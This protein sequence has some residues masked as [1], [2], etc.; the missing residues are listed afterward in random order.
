M[1]SVIADVHIGNHKKFG[2]PLVG[3]LNR[4]CRLA[5]EVLKKAVFAAGSGDLVIC[6]DLFDV[7]YPSPPVVSAVMGALSRQSGTTY[8]L[9]G[10]HDMHSSSGSDDAL[11]PLER[12]TGVRVV[13]EKTSMV[14]S[15]YRAV[16]LP[17][18]SSGSAADDL[19]TMEPEAAD[20]RDHV[21]FG[22]FGV[23]DE[24]TPPFLRNSGGSMDASEALKHLQRVTRFGLYGTLYVGDWHNRG[25]WRTDGARE[26]PE[27]I[28][29]CGALVPTGFDNPGVHYG[30]VKTH[31]ST[32]V[33]QIPGPRFLQFTFEAFE[34]EDLTNMKGLSKEDQVF[35]RFRCARKNRPD[36]MAKIRK[37]KDAGMIEDGDTS[38]DGEVHR[39]KAKQAALAAGGE[40]SVLDQI[41]AYVA[42]MPLPAGVERDVVLAEVMRHVGKAQ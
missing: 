28:Y 39:A 41:G 11:A 31:T 10:N 15:G 17:Y 7:A 16:F 22:H 21:I 12:V 30:F 26:S 6:G 9:R 5:V 4:R 36:A 19:R 42:K 27:R 34:D 29:Q 2:G 33:I 24:S 18:V 1:I 23:S 3:G 20:P 38:I 32:K 40:R 35:I 13:R 25:E 14:L 8:I 37:M